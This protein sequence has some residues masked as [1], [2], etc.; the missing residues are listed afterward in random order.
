[1]REGYRPQSEGIGQTEEK[2][3]DK[4]QKSRG[5]IDRI[6]YALKVGAIVG[7]TMLGTGAMR[8][9]EAVAAPE[10]DKIT[11]KEHKWTEAQERL[12]N[13]MWHRT[14]EKV[15]EL[16]SIY[17]QK[18]KDTLP[19]DVVDFFQKEGSDFAVAVVE[20]NGT[21][22]DFERDLQ[23]L[24][25]IFRKNLIGGDST[26]AETVPPTPAQTQEADA[27]AQQQESEFDAFV[28]KEEAE[29][30][31]STEEAQQTM[32]ETIEKSEA[33]F[34]ELENDP[35]FAES[36][37]TGVL[38]EKYNSTE[39]AGQRD[40]M[41]QEILK[42]YLGFEIQKGH[43]FSEGKWSGTIKRIPGFIMELKFT[44]D[45]DGNVEGSITDMFSGEMS[46]YQINI[47]ELK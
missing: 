29:F 36:D 42:T 45:K 5:I 2:K 21:M 46:G 14:N 43:T 3:Q 7:G 39:N 41:R 15:M 16:D 23:A 38:A 40:T 31:Q 4:H 37:S 12:I 35:A 11:D 33:A 8:G 1:M 47:S 26:A 18:N 17:Y 19:T 32:G 22:E 24:Y 28:N 6:K 27:S 44:V 34:M 9:G 30:A 13:Q 10:K 20:G 25:D